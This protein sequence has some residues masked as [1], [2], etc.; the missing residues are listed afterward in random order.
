MLTLYRRHT[1]T[2]RYRARGRAWRR[3][4]CPVWVDGLWHG[5]EIRQSLKTD[6][7]ETA[8]QIIETWQTGQAAREISIPEACDAFKAEAVARGVTQSTHKKYRHLFDRLKAW[9]EH[10]GIVHLNQIDVA[11]ARE[12][13]ASWT[14]SAIS[15]NKMLERLRSFFRFCCESEWI[16]RN[17]AA[18]LRRAV[19]TQPPTMPY[20]RDELRRIFRKLEEHRAGKT[21]R[22]REDAERLRAL[23]LVLRWSTLRI[24]DAVML[25]RDHVLGD[26]ILLRQAKTKVPVRIPVPPAVIEALDAVPNRGAY[27][28]C[29]GDGKPETVSGNWRL[30]LRWLFR[31]AAIPGGHAHRFRDTLAVELLEAGVPIDRVSQLL[32]HRSIRTTEKHYA[33][34]VKSRQDQLEREVRSSWNRLEGTPGVHSKRSTSVTQTNPKVL[35]LVSRAGLEPATL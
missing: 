35:R 6:R 17:P 8:Q 30:M 32:G 20:T 4:S 29:P 24:G 21:G 34:W 9:C 28:F 2:C 31:A 26:C 18:S 3:C 16:S 15:S 1:Q 22:R 27:Y 7:W 13:R 14:V 25:R 10:K 33:P 23:V 11:S 12:F 19:E 5:A